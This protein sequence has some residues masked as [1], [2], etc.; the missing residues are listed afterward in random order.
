MFKDVY[1]LSYLS[2]LRYFKI[3]LLSFVTQP[4][5]SPTKGSCSS[6]IIGILPQILKTAPP[7]NKKHIHPGFCAIVYVYE[8]YD[9]N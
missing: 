6:L 2:H 9:Y 7:P 4:R 5:I 8:F 1:N 3:L